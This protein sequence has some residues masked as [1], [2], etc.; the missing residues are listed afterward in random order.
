MA[1]QEQNQERDEVEELDE[2]L[3]LQDRDSSQVVGGAARAID[4][5]EPPIQT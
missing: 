3:D 4:E 1:E 5:E 2:D